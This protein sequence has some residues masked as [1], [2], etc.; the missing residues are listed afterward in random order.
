MIVKSVGS[1]DAMKFVCLR[2]VV[3]VIFVVVFLFRS[4]VLMSDTRFGGSMEGH[5][6]NRPDSGL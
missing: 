4:A 5:G 1:G 6:R 3:V 2:L